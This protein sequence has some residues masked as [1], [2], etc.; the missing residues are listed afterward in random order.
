MR[1]LVVED[2]IMIGES[3]QQALR[4]DGYAVD[5]TQNGDEAKQALR[6]SIY[7]LVLLDIGLPGA[8]GIEILQSL[9]RMK[10]DVSVLIITARDSIGDRVTG[11]DAGADDYLVKP[12]SL[13]E[14]EAR[15][16]AI[17][18]RK[19]GRSD[20]VVNYGPFMLNP[21]TKEFAYDG[22]AET[23]SQREFAIMGALLERPGA[24][25]S[26]AQLEERLYGWNEEVGSNAVE[27]HIHQLRKRFGKD[28]I[29]NIRGIGYT[30]QKA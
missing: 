26:R 5:W 3:L 11:L 21:V 19:A 10:N 29:R 16:R 30:V 23:L 7:D 24:V 9:R 18:R 6:D 2:D 14:L 13:E 28:V 12:F 8:T 15:I 25:L 22:R 17:T 20:P 4:A 1:L 27:V